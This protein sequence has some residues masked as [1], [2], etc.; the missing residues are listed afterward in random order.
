M[1]D[2]LYFSAWVKDNR[3]QPLLHQFQRML[4]RF[5][6]SKLARRGPVLRVY[7]IERVEPP[8]IEREF[9]PEIPLSEIINAARESM[10]AD[11]AAEVDTYWDLWSFE[12]GDWKLAPAPATLIAFGPDFERDNDDDLRIEFG[13]DGRFLPTAGVEGSLRM[14]QSNLRSLLHLT[15]ELESGLD[16]QKRQVWSESGA[17]FADV[18]RQ[19]LGQF[20]VN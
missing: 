1:P 8:L 12:N 20:H 15:G 6:I 5:P 18:L 7:A 19:A 16:L 13:P 4:E 3:T 11:S 10:E 14:G 17:N 9:P 2:R